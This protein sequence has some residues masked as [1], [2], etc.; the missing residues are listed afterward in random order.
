MRKFFLAAVLFLMASGAQAVTLNVIGGILHG[1]SDVLVDGSFYDV[2]FLEGTCIDLF[3]G[4]DN[5]SDFTFQTSASAALAGQALLDQVFL[6]GPSGDF[7]SDTS[8]TFGCDDATDS[9]LA[10]TPYMASPSTLLFDYVTTRNVSAHVTGI[11]DWVLFATSGMSLDT[12]PPTSPTGYVFASWSPVPEPSTAV[13]LGI[14]LAGL[15]AR[16]RPRR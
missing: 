2:Q 8:L 7:D 15:A 6:D 11:L 14:G 5:S 9:C 3:N 1:A 16:R 13:L 4:C 10:L 12:S